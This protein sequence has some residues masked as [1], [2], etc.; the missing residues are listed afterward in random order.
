MCWGYLVAFL[1]GSSEAVVSRGN[2]KT[3][4]EKF[5]CCLS[6]VMWTMC[7][8]IQ[9]ASGASIPSVEA[10]KGWSNIF[11]THRKAG[12]LCLSTRCYSILDRKVPYNTT[13]SMS[14]S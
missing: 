6:A 13:S 10:M 14:A 8:R 12:S 1:P 11:L 2:G 5:F 3:H 4:P 9:V 7:W